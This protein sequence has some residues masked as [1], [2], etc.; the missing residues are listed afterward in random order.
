MPAR[1]VLDAAATWAYMRRMRCARTSIALIAFVLAAA[2]TLAADT[3]ALVVLDAAGE[4]VGTV[5]GQ[6]V[7]TQSTSGASGDALLWIAR[8]IDGISTLLLVGQSAF[9]DTKNLVPL[10][11]EG[12]D[13]TGPALLDA[14]PGVDGYAAAVIFDT[15]VFWPAGFGVSR[16]V[17]SKA[18]LVRDPKDCT[19][20]LVSPQLCCAKLAGGETRLTAP[21]TGVP[22]ADLHLRIPFR[23]E[24]GTT[25]V[26]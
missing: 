14:P 19:D 12:D 20:L 23:L 16:L 2:P 6:A 17:R 7:R 22:M 10:L 5:V 8:P 24:Q 4:M 26:E 11:Y 13:C 1:C 9:S 25:A 15:G 18:T 21:V 3:P